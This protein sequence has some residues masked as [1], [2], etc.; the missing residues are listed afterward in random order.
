MNKTPAYKWYRVCGTREI[1]AKEGRRV[2]FG[3]HQIALFHLG[4]EF[5]AIDNACP[6]KQGPLADGILAGS[7]VFCPL[8]GWKIDLKTGCALNGGQ[9]QVKTYPVKVVE[10]DVYVAFGEGKLNAS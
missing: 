6:H 9:G 10:G 3:D 8:H 5:C 4:N 1:P 2:Q 7:S